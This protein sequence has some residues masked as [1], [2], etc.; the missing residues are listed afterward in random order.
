MRKNNTQS[1]STIFQRQDPFTM[2]KAVL[3]DSGVPYTFATATDRSLP[4]PIINVRGR[5]LSEMQFNITQYGDL[6][7]DVR[8]NGGS[9]DS[10]HPLH[11]IR[12]FDVSVFSMVYVIHVVGDGF[13]VTMHVAKA[14]KAATPQ[15]EN[16]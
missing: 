4:R 14:E 1:T 6:R 2:I 8:V 11:A 15:G 7:I 5:G 12:A 10:R 13:D 16:K 3:D 9:I